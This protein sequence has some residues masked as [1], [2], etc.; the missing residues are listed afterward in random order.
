MNLVD[1]YILRQLLN[2]FFSNTDSNNLPLFCL[3]KSVQFIELMVGRGLPFYIFSKLIFLSLPQIIPILLPIIVSLAI[4]FVFSR[5]QTDKELI[6]LQSSSFS[7]S[8][9]I[10][11]NF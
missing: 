9:I 4:F 10:K 2:I 7:R 5:M 8:I 3:A 1:K 11:L 6:I